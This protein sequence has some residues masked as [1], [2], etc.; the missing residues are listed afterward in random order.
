MSRQGFWKILKG[1]GELAG[2][3][4]DIT[5]HTLRHSFAVNM[6]GSGANMNALQEILGHST[7]TTTQAYANLKK[8]RT[9][10]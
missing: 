3:T 8:K 4:E 1:Y 5:P 6:I 2:I 10:K 7:V 9:R